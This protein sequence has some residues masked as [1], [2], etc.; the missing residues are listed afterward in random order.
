[1]GKESNNKHKLLKLVRKVGA[2]EIRELGAACGSAADGAVRR[3]DLARKAPVRLVPLGAR[4]HISYNRFPSLFVF[5]RCAVREMHCVLEDKEGK[6]RGKKV[7]TR[8]GSAS[9]SSVYPRLSVPRT[10]NTTSAATSS[11]RRSIGAPHAP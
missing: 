9:R 10:V 8:R 2:E 7:Q 11:S 4:Q 6:C 1:M 5:V 3:V